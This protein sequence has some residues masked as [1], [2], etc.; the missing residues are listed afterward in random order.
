MCRSI[1]I[2]SNGLNP[3]EN[4]GRDAGVGAWT[5][6]TVLSLAIATGDIAL[7]F[8]GDSILLNSYR[9]GGLEGNPEHDILPIADAALDA[10]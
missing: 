3:G 6:H 4:A 1:V 10:P 8:S 2:H 7:T 9:A 5:I